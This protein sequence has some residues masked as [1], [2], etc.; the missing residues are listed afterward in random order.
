VTCHLAEDYYN[1]RLSGAGHFIKA[2]QGRLA[3]QPQTWLKRLPTHFFGSIAQI[4]TVSSGF[5]D[6]YV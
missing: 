3:A 2:L 6:S 1:D 4:A 5:C